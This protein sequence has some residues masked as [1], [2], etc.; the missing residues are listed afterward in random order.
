[1]AAQKTEWVL[2]TMKLRKTSR[3]F[4]LSALILAGAISGSLGL[5]KASQKQQSTASKQAAKAAVVPFQA[6]ETLEYRLSWS[7]F[8]T[9]ATVHLDVLERRNLYGWDAWHFRAMGST[10]APLRTLFAIDDEFDSYA[11]A[12]TFGGHQFEEYLDELGRK[13]K[14]IMEL[15]PQGTVPRGSV[16]SVIV[17]PATRDPL[18]YLESLR[19]YDWE[20]FAELRVPV[21]DGKT[22]YDIQAVRE[23]ADDKISLPALKCDCRRIGI[24]IFEKGKESTQTRIEIWLQSDAERMPVLIQAELPLGTFRMELAS[25]NE[26]GGRQ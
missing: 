18:G 21:F 8:I 3:P 26:N 20:R 6:G 11:D 16:A 9:A 24:H 15:T 4:A 14:N 7:T 25:F 5:S 19:A 12:A 13:D 17:P 1:M 22:L 10:E 23:A 2:A